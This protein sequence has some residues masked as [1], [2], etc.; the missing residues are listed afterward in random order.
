MT[1]IPDISKWLFAPSYRNE[2]EIRGQSETNPNGY[3]NDSPVISKRESEQMT[4]ISKGGLSFRNESGEGL[5]K[6]KICDQSVYDFHFEMSAIN[7][8]V[9]VSHWKW[10]AER[11]DCHFEMTAARRVPLGMKGG[12]AAER[13]RMS[14]QWLSFREGGGL[15]TFCAKPGRERGAIG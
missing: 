8:R 2:R 7:H 5:I 12:V 14:G 10:R 6:M 3:R 9:N 11:N 13:A 1:V 15:I 4:V